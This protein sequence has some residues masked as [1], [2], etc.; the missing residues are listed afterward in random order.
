M[1]AHYVCRRRL[2]RRRLLRAP[3]AA[4]CLSPRRNAVR[5][6]ASFH[7]I[8][9]TRLRRTLC[10]SERRDAMASSATLRREMLACAMR[11]ERHMLTATCDEPLGII[12]SKSRHYASDITL[13]IIDITFAIIY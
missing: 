2:S 5:P 4:V 7:F 8:V 12:V 1:H 13:L 11:D 10:A 6:T 3:V 9:F